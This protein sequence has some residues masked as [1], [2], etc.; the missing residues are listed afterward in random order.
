MANEM[1]EALTRG[2]GVELGKPIR[3]S[4]FEKER[5]LNQNVHFQQS[6]QWQKQLITDMAALSIFNQQVILPYHGVSN[7]YRDSK[8]SG[9]SR[10]RLGDQHIDSEFMKTSSKI[11][12]EFFAITK[13]FEID[14]NH[15]HIS[16]I[17]DFVRFWLD[18]S[19]NYV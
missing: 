19:N 15:L 17:S 13:A 4:F 18:R 2:I 1:I 3:I 10:I 11:T 6:A 9:I 14:V 16:N 12:R 7:F 8:K 5:Y